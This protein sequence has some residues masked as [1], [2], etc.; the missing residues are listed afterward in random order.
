[1][2][3]LNPEI[4][5][6]VYIPE[7]VATPSALGAIGDL[8]SMATQGLKARSAVQNSSQYRKA[9]DDSRLVGL[10]DGLYK[11]DQLRKQGKKAQA[12]N[13]K[14]ARVHFIS[15]NICFRLFL[16]LLEPL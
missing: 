4:Q 2:G 11:A 1:M 7:P 16:I 5:G 9:Q 13:I 8:V 10:Q 3:T 6:S 15:S 14:A 12:A